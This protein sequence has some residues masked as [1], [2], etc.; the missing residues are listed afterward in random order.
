MPL[1]IDLEYAPYVPLHR[2]L[3]D[4]LRKA[5]LEGRLKL[6]ESVP[7]VRELSASHKLSKSTVVKAY[8]DLRKQGLLSSK[9]GSGTFVSLQLPDGDM[10]SLLEPSLSIA[11][12]GT[13]AKPA[14]LSKRGR[15]L[16][17]IGQQHLRH[18]LE[19]SCLNYEAQYSD[20]PAIKQWKALLLKRCHLPKDEDADLIADPFGLPALR[21]AIAA[22]LH[23]RRS[24]LDQPDS[25][26]V[27]GTKQLRVELISRLLLNQGDV[28]AYEDPG[29]PEIRYILLA[30]GATI[31]PLSLDAEGLSVQALQSMP[32]PPKLIYITPSSQ[33]PL[34][35]LMSLRRRKEI[36]DYAAQTG[37][38]ILE[39]DFNSEFSYADE[40]LPALKALDRH[41]SVIYMSTFWKVLY[42]S[43][44]LS[45][46][47]FPSCLT[48]PARV[49][50]LYME[51]SLP[52]VEQSA[53]TDFLAQGYLEKHLQRCR[54][55]LTIGR[56]LLLG[57]VE[58][59]LRNY[60]RKV[61]VIGSTYLILEFNQE[62]D[63]VVIETA[64]RQSGFQ[65]G[66]TRSY[67]CN[68]PRYGQY[69]VP[70]ATVIDDTIFG[71]VENFSDL[72]KTS[73]RF[74]QNENEDR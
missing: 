74:Q 47:V 43:V 54:N 5:I 29:F 68:S 19:M 71:I 46:V 73:Q 33:D 63:E 69:I 56:Q 72:L 51:R 59:Y 25:I 26:C 35:T 32:V 57:A 41:D 36:L 66:S 14:Q 11:S 3:S 67:Y 8:N 50:K 7:S 24:I 61:C 38:F 16:Y 39:D 52:L 60:S 58:K 18:Q 12:T 17:E 15:K 10:G 13:A 30:H 40:P 4:A 28:V 31:V 21:E 6:G 62:L 70:F 23:R 45:Y 44:S 65:I 42:R 49:A 22:Y 48:N 9:S 2:R 55:K 37:A 20:Y 1:T 27:F 64:A 34:T 53:L